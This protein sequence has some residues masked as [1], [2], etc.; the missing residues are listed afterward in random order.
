M[1]PPGI[2]SY[3]VFLLGFQEHGHLNKICSKEFLTKNME[4][5]RTRV[6]AVKEYESTGGKNE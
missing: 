3:N 6:S 2:S 5:I 4:K 1:M